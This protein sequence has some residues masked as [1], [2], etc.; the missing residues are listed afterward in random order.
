MPVGQMNWPSPWPYL[1][2]SLMSSSVPHSG[3]MVY[4][5]ILA[6]LP[7]R[8]HGVSGIISDGRVRRYTVSSVETATPMTMA[9]SR[10]P[11]AW[12]KS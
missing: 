11:A 9:R 2:N 3:P 7:V 4:L 12:E 1:P 10:L 6:G 8:S 5:P